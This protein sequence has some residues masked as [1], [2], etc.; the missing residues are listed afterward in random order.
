MTAKLPVVFSVAAGLLASGCMGSSEPVV[1]PASEAMAQMRA[2][3]IEIMRD[4]RDCRDDALLLDEKA[5][6][7]AQTARFLSSAEL[8]VSCDAKAGPEI[9]GVA[10]EERLRAR[11]LAVQNFL[12]G[13]DAKSA[14]VALNGLRRD[15]PGH[16]LYFADGASF[17]DTMEV[18]LGGADG[19][20]RTVYATAN[21]NADLQRELRRVDYWLK[22]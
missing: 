11:A 9:A 21:V 13:G 15:F 5:Q 18:L 8:L 19:R 7:H 6:S 22:N 1:D 16:D 3:R 2:E 4:W 17:V 20:K 12:K 14:L 10:V